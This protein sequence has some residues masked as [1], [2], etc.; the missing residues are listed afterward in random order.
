MT[1]SLDING[2]LNALLE[3]AGS[4][5]KSCL[6]LRSQDAP[7]GSVSLQLQQLRPD[8]LQ[9]PGHLALLHV[10]QDNLSVINCFVN[11]KQ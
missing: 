11:N 4:G 10:I 3:T 2:S 8:V 9:R 7:Q 1:V 5:D 6:L